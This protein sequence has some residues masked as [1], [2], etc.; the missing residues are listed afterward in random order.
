MDTMGAITGMIA[1]IGTDII[2]T[3][4]IVTESIVTMTGIAI[5]TG[6]IAITATAGAIA[7]PRRVQRRSELL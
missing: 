2:V 6:I 3:E 5:G 7:S 1:I 4:N